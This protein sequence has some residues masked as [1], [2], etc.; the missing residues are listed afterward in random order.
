VDG[1]SNSL[2]T[3]KALD[4]P[5]DE[6][7]AALGL[8]GL[9]RRNR[10]KSYLVAGDLSSVLVGYSV[11][12]VVT[13]YSS[14]HPWR[15]VALITVF[16]VMF[17]FWAIRSQG[18][19]LARVSAIRVVE[20]TRATRATAILGASVLLL[21]RVAHLDMRILE[22]GTASVLTLIALVIWR[23]TYR[24]WLTMA[25]ANG[26]FRRRVLLIG[27]NEETKRL[28]GLIETHRELGIQIVGLVGDRSAARR[29]GLE[30]LW[31]GAD[32][33]TEAVIR[34]SD[35]TGLVVLP[36]E[37]TS[38]RLNALIREVQR[39]GIHV[40][41]A[42]GFSGIDARRVRSLSLAHEP[43][44]YVEPPSL[45]R[46]QVVA[47]RAFDIAFSAVALVLTSPILLITALA[48]KFSD[49]G[50]VLFKQQRV[51]KGGVHFGVLKFRTMAVDAEQ[52]LAGL[53]EGNERNGPLFKMVAD[54][55]VTR[56]GRFLRDSSLDELPQLINVLRGQMSLVGPRPALP[57]EV[58]HFPEA[59]RARE[60]VMP[61]ITG[62]WQVEARDNP[63]FE[64][65]RRLDLFYVENWSLTLD[66]MI[67]VG[68]LEQ[69]SARLLSTVFRRH[70]DPEVSQVLS[71]LPNLEEYPDLD[72]I[73]ESTTGQTAS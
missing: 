41:V 14:S 23:S 4:V 45:A 30:R 22:V 37:I 7:R 65:Y 49:A 9:V 57:A 12:L 50:P 68:T 26:K 32:H 55:R 27:A 58:E 59:L 16:T 69:I 20:L 5:V 21:D 13:G 67:V 72:P 19:F 25:R 51:G 39:D 38:V 28:V 17:G 66:F 2:S 31:L 42:T 70:K 6:P 34:E 18:L 61:G 62:L 47:K 54:P 46:T 44:L 43:M 64:A 35:V 63:S 36:H 10:L 11:A 73:K 1:F 53:S 56:V 60:Q 29:S 8:R 40:F 3:E 52:Q 24:W 33:Q 15:F 71:L 48:V